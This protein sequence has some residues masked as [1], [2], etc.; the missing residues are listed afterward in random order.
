MCDTCEELDN[1][2]CVDND[3]LLTVGCRIMSECM[4]KLSDGIYKGL[5]CAC[6]YKENGEQIYKMPNCISISESPTRNPTIIPTNLSF[7]GLDD[8][9]T[10]STQTFEEYMLYF[11]LGGVAII[12]L[13]LLYFRNKVKSCLHHFSCNKVEDDNSEHD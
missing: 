4:N 3:C 6:G 7:L 9:N 11:I 2:E 13:V 8:I 12:L 5:T 1:I 10:N